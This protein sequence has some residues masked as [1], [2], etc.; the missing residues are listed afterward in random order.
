MKTKIRTVAAICVL[1]IL[2]AC[3]KK[4]EEQAMIDAAVALKIKLYRK[5][6]REDCRKEMLARADMMADSILLTRVNVRNPVV[7]PQR[8]GRPETPQVN[9]QDT[10]ELIKPGRKKE[11]FLPADSLSQGNNLR[12]TE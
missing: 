8:P 9:F 2:S 5:E 11:K 4:A 7:K 3:N 1:I 10:I 6:A 12:K